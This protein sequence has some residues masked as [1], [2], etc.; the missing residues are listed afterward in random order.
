MDTKNLRTQRVCTTGSPVVFFSQRSPLCDEELG[1]RRVYH[2]TFLTW[3]AVYFYKNYCSILAS[4]VFLCWLW[5]LTWCC[6]VYFMGFA[7]FYVD[8][9]S[10]RFEKMIKQRRTPAG[11]R[12]WPWHVCGCTYMCVCMGCILQ[13]FDTASQVSTF[14]WSLSSGLRPSEL[15]KSNH[16]G[17]QTTSTISSH[18]SHPL[19]CHMPTR[20]S[21]GWGSTY[22]QY[23]TSIGTSVQGHSATK[24]GEH[25]WPVCGCQTESVIIRLK[26]V[27]RHQ[28]TQ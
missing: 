28:Y 12:A 13:G 8:C 9:S 23:Q 4:A 14:I 22:I 16:T 24:Y 18:T 6:M 26:T 5:C 17:P 20:A 10:S 2:C 21:S 25:L 27:G 15:L 11:W 1:N 7:V 3:T 19:R